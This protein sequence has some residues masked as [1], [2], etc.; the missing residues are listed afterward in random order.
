MKRG[1][2]RVRLLFYILLSWSFVLP[3]SYL[4]SKIFRKRYILFIGRDDGKFTDNVKYLYLYFIEKRREFESKG[5]DIMFLTE[6]I[7]VYSVLKGNNLPVVKFPSIEALKVMLST[8]LLIVDNWMWIKN[9]KSFVLNF[10][11]KIQIWHGVGF[12]YIEL[13]NKNEFRNFKSK[14]LNRLMKRFPKYKA[15]VS[16]SGFYTKHVFSKAFNFE[17]IWE[18]GYPRNDIFFRDLKN[19]DL[20]FVD[21]KIL[22]IVEKKKKKGYKIVLYAPTFRDTGGDVFSDAVLDIEKLNNFLKKLKILM[23][24][25]FHPGSRFNFRIFRNCKN[26]VFY[27]GTKDIYPLLKNVDCLITDYSSIYMDY[28]LLDRPIIFFPYDFD[29]YIAED[30]EIQFDYDWITPGKK[31]FNQNELEKALQE[32]FLNNKDDFKKRR[33][34]I[35]SIAFKY[36]DGLACERIFHRILSM[37]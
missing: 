1:I 14:I 36:F 15:I 34:E 27:D 2:R 24:I 37:L 7:D 31:V 10:T 26:T 8:K 4:S 33:E 20:I 18:A 28:L 19:Y 22:N 11:E 32:V 30:R 35:R 16:T 6:N 5:L 21:D 9:F 29:K 3:I 17:E 25:K 13:E 23:V 12:K